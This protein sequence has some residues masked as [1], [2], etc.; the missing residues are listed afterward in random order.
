MRLYV[1]SCL[2]VSG[3]MGGMQRE[4]T[5]YSDDMDDRGSQLRIEVGD[6]TSSN[7]S[8]DEEDI[9]VN[10]ALQVL[11][12]NSLTVP[13]L[14]EFYVKKI[15]DEDKKSPV[16]DQKRLSLS[17]YRRDSSYRSLSPS[18]LSEG[19]LYINDVLIKASQKA[20]EDQEKVLQD[21]RKRMKER[22]NKRSVV[23][24][25]GSV[26]AVVTTVASLIVKYN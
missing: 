19:T 2:L 23:I 15:I 11:R 5:Q 4:I 10:A 17:F 3:L 8:F 21:I 24:L 20:L 22:L 1:I 12:K 13:K 7:S 18:S 9:L 25:V 16:I 6:F 14:V 26:S